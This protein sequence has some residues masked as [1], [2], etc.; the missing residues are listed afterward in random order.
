MDSDEQKRRPGSD[1]LRQKLAA[2]RGQ[3]ER[4][5][6]RADV[7]LPEASAPKTSASPSGAPEPSQGEVE[8]TVAAGESLSLISQK[9]YGSQADWPRIYQANKAIIGDDP[10]RIRVGQKLKIPAK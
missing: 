4:E 5:A 7:D 8:H 2:H 9:Y 10:N 1:A 3:P 6:I